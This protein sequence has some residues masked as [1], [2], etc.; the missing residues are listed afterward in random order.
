[1]AMKRRATQRAVAQETSI[2]MRVVPTRASREPVDQKVDE[3]S[4]R[5]RAY[6]EATTLATLLNSGGDLDTVLNQWTEV[7]KS[8]SDLIGGG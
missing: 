1:M 3:R 8:L 5:S 2:E 7:N 6:H 4:K